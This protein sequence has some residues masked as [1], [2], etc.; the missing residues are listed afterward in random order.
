M[1]KATNVSTAKPSVAGAISCAAISDTLTLPT[2]ADAAL[3]EDFKALG[4]VSEDG[5]TNTPERSSEE[6]KAWGGDV[7]ITSQT[8]F[9]DSFSFTL[10]ESLNE[11]VIK[12]VFGE[13]NV[14]G[15]IDT[16]L[17][18]KVNSAE[19]DPLAWV[20]DMI[21]T[22]GILKRVVIPQGKI[23]ELGEI[24]Y[25]DGEAIGYTLTIA[26]MPDKDG[27]THYEYMKKGNGSND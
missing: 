7:V 5:L 11:E 22:G 1:N 3:P 20:V 23:S 15:T 16:G 21:L 14:S 25:K 10:I 24:A 12:S 4:Y 2:T 17:T 9:K 26:S 8:E 27:N 13:K 18:I 19:L 6:I